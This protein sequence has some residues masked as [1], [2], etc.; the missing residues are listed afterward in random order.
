MLV[1]L[2]CGV[3]TT[4]QNTAKDSTDVFFRHFDV[5][6]VV[7]Q[8]LTGQTKMKNAPAP[9]SIVTQRELNALS[10]TNIIDAIAS[11]PGL[12]QV[13]TGSGI[14]KPVIRGLGYNRIVTVSDGVRQ[15][16][17]Q[18]GDEHGIEIDGQG[19]HQVEILKGPASLMYGSDAM[20]GVLL[21]HSAPTLPQGETRAQL[22]TEYQTNNGLYGYSLNLGGHQQAWVWDVRY[23]DRRAHA[24]KNKVDGYVPGSQFGERGMSGMLGRV[25]TWGHSRL[26]LSYYELTPSIVEGERDEQTGELEFEGTDIKTYGHA[27][28]YQKV[29]HT[30]GVW[31]NALRLPKGML[32][33]I[34]GYQQN[35]RQEFEE[36]ADEYGL[37]FRL[38]TATYDLRYEADEWQGWK[39]TTGIGGMW[40]RSENLGDEYLIPSYRLLDAGL[41]ATTSKQIDRW[42]L[43]GGLRYDHRALHSYALTDEGELRFDDFHRNFSGLTGSVGA[44]LN[45]TEHANVRLN[46]ARGFRAPNLSELGSNG[47]HEGTGRYEV[48]NNQLKAEYSW[49]ADLGIDYSSHLLTAQVAVFANRIDNY[50]Y[51]ARTQHPSPNIHHPTPIIQHPAP[52]TYNF[53]QGDARLLGFEAGFDIHPIHRLHLGSTF[54]MVDAQQ[55]HQ[56]RETRYLP[57]T[58]A[59]RWKADVKYELTHDGR[60]LNNAYVAVGMECYLRQ[61]HYYEAEQTETATPS[62]TLLSA[63]AGTDLLIGGRKAAELYL[64]GENLTN[65]AYQSHLSRLKYL[66]GGGVCNMGR[67]MTLKLIVPLA[68]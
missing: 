56:P 28:P 31:D 27:L 4:A 43:S 3:A 58:P 25:G 33:A 38:H 39:L 1:W 15:E 54:S 42:T 64:I 68:L 37:Y 9:I 47:E 61:S 66:D 55:L 24:Y 6:E 57:F 21:M 5:G 13:T 41:Y 36:S 19:V 45:I 48:G 46:L 49:Q 17:Q 53:Q 16:G 20:A 14:S 34:V 29:R 52:D 11:E 59:P 63:S 44:V 62:Y 51:L 10:A 18:W 7:V 8:G 22:N 30:K 12:A 60:V 50:I 35:R 26:K 2:C 23:T 67:N 65:R 32:K 40:Q